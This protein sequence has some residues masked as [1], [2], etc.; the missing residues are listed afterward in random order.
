M[1]KHVYSEKSNYT[2][3]YVN[4]EIRQALA[5][6]SSEKVKPD[7]LLSLMSMF[8]ESDETKF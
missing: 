3:I 6:N 1:F 2:K 4:H 8:P 5:L 7:F